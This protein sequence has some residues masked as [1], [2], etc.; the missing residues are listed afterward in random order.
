MLSQND[1]IQK[2]NQ[3]VVAEILVGKTPST[4]SGFP[5][6]K[7][8]KGLSLHFG[9]TN[10]DNTDEWAYRLRYPETGISFLFSD[11]GNPEYLGY[12]F[13]AM[14][15]ME[16]GIF[17]KYSK[18]LS[19][20][21][22]MGASY[23]TYNYKYLP[24]SFNNYPENN[25]RGVS[26]NLT[27]AF[28]VLFNY[29][30]IKKEQT[31]WKVGLGFLHQSNGHTRL[32]NNGYNT[33]L[34]SVSRQSFYNK[35]KPLISDLRENTPSFSKSSQYYYDL[36]MGAG[37]NVLS[38]SSTARKG[39]YPIAP[40]FGKIINKTFKIGVGF[41]YRFYE[42]YYDYIINEGE[43]VLEDN[44]HFTEKPVLYASK[45]GVFITSELLLGHIGLEATLGYNIY[46][47]FMKPIGD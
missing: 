34:V 43:L 3:F 18:R 5:E 26:T 1:S 36:R 27:W 31:D 37:L 19:M 15:F 46:K 11:Y 45:F 24:Y 44:L 25:S 38:E 16:Y 33:V 40:S 9:N 39:V 42:N 29:A 23:F 32:P 17:K 10:K 28:K 7:L 8:H 22:G 13:S 21:L 12:S 41:Y 6:T 14:S 4:N 2:G 47:P 30:F 20:Q 35:P